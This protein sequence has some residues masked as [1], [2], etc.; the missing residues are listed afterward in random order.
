MKKDPLILETLGDHTFNKYIQAK[1][2]E[3]D[4]Y[5]CLIHKWELDR[6]LQ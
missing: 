4:D 3:W 2:L 6:Y 5:R 1:E